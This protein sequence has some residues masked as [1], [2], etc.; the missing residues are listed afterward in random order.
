MIRMTAMALL[1]LATTP[2]LAAPLS[3]GRQP[4]YCR[5]QAASEF[6][7]K[8]VYIKTGQRKPD[9]EC[10][11]VIDGSHD[12]MKTFRCTFSNSGEFIGL[13][14]TGTMAAAAPAVKT[15]PAGK[16]PSTAAINA[17]NKSK[18]GEKDH[19]EGFTDLCDGLYGVTLKY[20]SGFKRCEF[21]KTGE[22]RVDKFEDL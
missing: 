5:G 17:C 9:G 18:K 16:G 11:F 10:S 6:A 8:P 21:S 20:S 3:P 7:T 22:P 13:T 14:R 15:A 12:G 1:S 19:V 2:V 4:A